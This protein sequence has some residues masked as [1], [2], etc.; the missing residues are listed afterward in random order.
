MRMSGGRTVKWFREDPLANK[1]VRTVGLVLV[2]GVC[3]LGWYYFGLQ[4]YRR[5]HTM[6]RDVHVFVILFLVLYP[7]PYLQV[8][9]KN[10]QPI[11]I[12]MSVY[13]LLQAASFIMF[14]IP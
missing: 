9:K 6:R 11:I 12:V 8:L 4:F 2:G 10:P 14:P 1:K 7:L 5:W 13:A 3:L